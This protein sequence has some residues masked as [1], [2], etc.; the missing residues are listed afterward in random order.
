MNDYPA[1]AELSD[2]PVM[3]GAPLSQSDLD[4]LA[5]Q[6]RAECGWHIAPV[7]TE[8]LTLNSDGAPELLLPS[9]NVREVTAVR[10]VKGNDIT[11]TPATHWNPRTGWSTEG[12]LYLAGG[13]PR[14]LRTVE[15]DLVHGY[16]KAPADLLRLVAT[17]NGRRIVQESLRGHSIT[18]AEGGDAYGV[19]S[20][21]NAYRID[22]R[23]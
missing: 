5:Q 6:I 8:T 2:L 1:L 14:G 9:L 23:P 3:A 11:A 19:A 20:I 12:V 22:P 17:R 15:V 18:F 13:F 4:A 7:V 10:T 16:D 21:L